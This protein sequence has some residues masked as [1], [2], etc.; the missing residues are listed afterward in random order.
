MMKKESMTT[1]KTKLTKKE[2]LDLLEQTEKN[3][4]ELFR[5]ME[6][7]QTPRDDAFA[8]HHARGEWFSLYNLKCE[9]EAA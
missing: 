2:L 6:A 3:A 5:A 8:V 1:I 7:R 4:W 9:V